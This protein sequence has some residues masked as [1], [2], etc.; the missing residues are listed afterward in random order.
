[1]DHQPNRFC[2]VV[3][4]RAVKL[5][6]LQQSLSSLVEG[7]SFLSLINTRIVYQKNFAMS[8]VFFIFFLFFLLKFKKDKGYYWV[9]INASWRP[10]WAL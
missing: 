2:W 7:F 4:L 6:F 1:V 8:R 5:L 9:N 10:F 3:R